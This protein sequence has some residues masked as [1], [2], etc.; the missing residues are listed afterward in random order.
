MIRVRNTCI[1]VISLIA[2]GGCSS[3]GKAAVTAQRNDDVTKSGTLGP[4]GA[5][6]VDI[7]SRLGRQ[8][9]VCWDFPQQAHRPF[10]IK[11]VAREANGAVEEYLLS[12]D[13][14]G[15][16]ADCVRLGPETGHSAA[17][18]FL[19]NPTADPI[20]WTITISPTI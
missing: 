8:P 11:M 1:I 6:S 17:S 20:D 18:V 14:G 16:T 5:A 10:D 9:L 15:T 2:L 7:P 19:S 13:E 3:S 4:L 12:G